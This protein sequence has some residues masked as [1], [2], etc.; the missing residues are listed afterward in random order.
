MAWLPA[1][2]PWT[3]LQRLEWSLDATYKI[4]LTSRKTLAKV[5]STI[6]AAVSFT[7]RP[8]Y[9]QK[10]SKQGN[11][12]RTSMSDWLGSY[13]ASLSGGSFVW[14]GMARTL[15]ES[16][17]Q[18]VDSLNIPTGSNHLSSCESWVATSLRSGCF[19]AELPQQAGVETK[20]LEKAVFLPWH[21]SSQLEGWRER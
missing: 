9:I 7:T 15:S 14:K 21:L 16:T 18:L 5:I 19:L 13:L 1:R 6:P 12:H 8:W 20:A 10:G 4:G 11:R 3:F 17:N 2:N